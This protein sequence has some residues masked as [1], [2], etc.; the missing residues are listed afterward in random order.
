M[1]CV[2]QA[3]SHCIGQPRD[4]LHRPTACRHQTYARANAVD[5]IINPFVNNESGP[6][7]PFVYPY[8]Y[9]AASVIAHTAWAA[10]LRAVGRL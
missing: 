9:N 4:S 7:L 1:C 2:L 8:V 5:V 10:L 3:V 6:L